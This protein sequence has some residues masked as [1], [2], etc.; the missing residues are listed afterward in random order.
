MKRLPMEEGYMNL[1]PG[2][3]ASVRLLGS[4]SAAA[5]VTFF[6]MRKRCPITG[7]PVATVELSAEG[8]LYS[9]SFIHMPKMGSMEVQAGGGYGVGQVDLPE[10]VRVQTLIDG[11]PED[12]EIG[13]RMRIEANVVA[14]DESGTEYCGFKFVPATNDS[15]GK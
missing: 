13:M 12:F 8:T 14:T 4:Y 9:W 2:A 3:D 1:S 5:D 11:R 6:P 15:E 7:E 10:G